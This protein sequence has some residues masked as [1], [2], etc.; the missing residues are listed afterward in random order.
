MIEAN[1]LERFCFGGPE[2]DYQLLVMFMGR[3]REREA[4][5]SQ[6]VED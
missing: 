3:L 1:I 2:K 6:D 4:A 5:L